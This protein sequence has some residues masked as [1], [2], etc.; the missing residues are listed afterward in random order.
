MGLGKIEFLLQLHPPEFWAILVA[1]NDLGSDDYAEHGA[2][3]LGL[4][5]GGFRANLDLPSDGGGDKGGA[6]LLQA[7]QR[8]ADFRCHLRGVV[9][10]ALG[11]VGNAS[12]LIQWRHR[13]DDE[14][15]LFP[16]Q[17]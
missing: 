9:D 2:V 15:E 14:P 7:F 17:P 5:C 6:T 13:Q 11:R 16:I 1:V 4:T 12:L 10:F 3:G 8:S